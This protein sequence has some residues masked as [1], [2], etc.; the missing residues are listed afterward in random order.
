VQPVAAH[1]QVAPA[2]QLMTQPPPAQAPMLHTSPV[3][4]SIVQPPPL[5]SVMV[6]V[7]FTESATGPM[8]Q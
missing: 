1:W 5:Q 4:Q 6:K 8:W 7:E 2:T 3:L